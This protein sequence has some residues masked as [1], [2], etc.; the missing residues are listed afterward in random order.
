MIAITTKYHGP[1]NTIGSRLSCRSAGRPW[2]IFLSYDS[3]SSE[4][5]KH[6]RALAKYCHK[7]FRK[8][9]AEPDR[10]IPYH[11]GHTNEGMVFV[12]LSPN[13]H[14]RDTVWVNN[15]NGAYMLQEPLECKWER[16]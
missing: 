10:W 6:T 1:T 14:A 4:L 8:H 13:D 5:E 7:Y 3:G 12:V 15:A 2:R 9:A 16:E 11:Y